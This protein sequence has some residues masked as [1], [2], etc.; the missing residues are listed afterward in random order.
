VPEDSDP[1]MPRGILA[2]W[3][4]GSGKTLGFIS[5]GLYTLTR[6]HKQY[7]NGIIVIITN[8][9]LQLQT[10]NEVLNYVRRLNAQQI[11]LDLL[12]TP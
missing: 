7:A 4:P 5:A 1:I 11:G 10:T 12:P 8:K 9:S 2:F 3:K 6:K